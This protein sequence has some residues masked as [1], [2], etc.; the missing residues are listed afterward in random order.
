MRKLR[1]SSATISVALFLSVGAT[2]Q[3]Q[4]Q[5]EGPVALAGPRFGLTLLTG[6]SADDLK[7]DHDV[8]PII[9]QVGW[10]FEHRFSGAEGGATGITEFVALVGG[11]EQGFILP[12][13]SGLVGFRSANGSEFGF[14][15]SLSLS[16]AAL[17][18][19]AGITKQSGGLNLPINL[20][21]VLSKKGTQF[22]LLFGF[23]ARR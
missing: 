13:L 8:G 3:G 18:V 12:S 6:K 9:L 15:P 19:A 16:G 5:S 4:I 11:V 23:N 20:A 17:V 22:S 1:W 14:G 10:Q 7:E 2:A 21:V